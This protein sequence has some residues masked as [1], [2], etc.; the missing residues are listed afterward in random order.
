VTTLVALKGLAEKKGIHTEDP[1]CTAEAFK[2][3][4]HRYFPFLAWT[5]ATMPGITDIHG[6]SLENFEWDPLGYTITTKEPE[7]LVTTPKS[8]E[9]LM[10][11]S[12]LLFV[13]MKS[14]KLRAYC[15]LER[16]LVTNH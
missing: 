3:F 11:W 10:F 1:A 16:F 5:T 14:V 9:L 13:L 15:S 4:V 12:D 6:L 8:C 2:T 7:Q